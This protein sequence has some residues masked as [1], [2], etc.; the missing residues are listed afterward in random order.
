MHLIRPEQNCER[1]HEEQG[2]S[3]TYLEAGHMHI[4]TNSRLT[5]IRHARN[6][7]EVGRLA[8]S[9]SRRRDMFGLPVLACILRTRAAG[10]P[11]AATSGDACRLSGPD[12]EEAGTLRAQLA[13]ST[14]PGLGL[15]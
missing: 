9:L 3:S 5:P 7:A 13:N 4:Q 10:H 14:Q 12:L 15:P 2:Q 8:E 1:Q 11:L 6:D